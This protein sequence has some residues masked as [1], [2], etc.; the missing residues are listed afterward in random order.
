M[1]RI[2][3]DKLSVLSPK[4]HWAKNI[5]LTPEVIRGAAMTRGSEK[6][7]HREKVRVKQGDIWLVELKWLP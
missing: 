5:E 4:V 1:S 7:F 3:K 6:D 2:G